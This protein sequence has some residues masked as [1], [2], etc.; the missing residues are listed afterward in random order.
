MTTTAI[1]LRAAGVAALLGGGAR[2]VAAVIPAAPGSVELE[3]LYTAIDG[4][5]LLGLFGFYARRAEALGLAGLVA[6]T[7]A[8]CAFSLIGGPDA[9][10][11]GFSTY[12]VGASILALAMALLG[13][14][15][16]VRR[17]AP[18]WAPL[19]WIAALGAGLATGTG[20]PWAFTAAGILF[21]A[22]FVA[23]GVELVR[24]PAPA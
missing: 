19:G 7:L 6:F 24:G 13:V 4:F 21:G 1:A 23:A 22:G 16:L 20:A 2:I 17:S 18:P 5:L 10:P 9:D 11:F 8:V 12:Q 14:A 3:A 15:A